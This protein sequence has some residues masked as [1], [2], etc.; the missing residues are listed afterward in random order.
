MPRLPVDGKKVIEH[1]ITFGT[2]ERDILE[3]FSTAYTVKSVLPSIAEIMT[4]ATA[5]YAIGVLIET[6]FDVDLPFIYTTDDAQELWQGLEQYF[7]NLD[8]TR[9]DRTSFGGGILYLFDQFFYVMSGGL[10][11]KFTADLER[12]REENES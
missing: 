10:Q 8:L 9:E 7:K 2:K 4:D 3:G 12:R 1:R 5:L 11:D 6:I